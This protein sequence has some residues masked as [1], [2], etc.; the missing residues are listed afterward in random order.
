MLPRVMRVWIPL[1]VLATCAIGFAYLVG[2]QAWRLGADGLPEQLAWDGS[3]AI[4][5]GT[6]AESVTGTR[7]VDIATS[8]APWVVVFDKAGVPVTGTGML[9]GKLASPPKGVLEAAKADGPHGDR[10]TWQPHAGVRQ[11]IVVHTVK[12]G[13][14]GYVVAGRSLHEVEAQVDILTALAGAAWVATLIATLAA[15]WVVEWSFGRR[16]RTA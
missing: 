1:A 16:I 3:V 9:D 10:V 13:P 15:V 6:P 14:G 11:A 12:A 2:Q 4:A 7:P 5:A 8:I